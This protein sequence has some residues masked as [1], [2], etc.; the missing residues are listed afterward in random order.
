MVKGSNWI[1]KDR[2]GKITMYNPPVSVFR[3]TE[4]IN[5][6]NPNRKIALEKPIYRL[7]MPVYDNKV[8]VSWR[9][10]AGMMESAE[11]VYDARKTIINK[12]T[13]QTTLVPAKIL[14]KKTGKL[15]QLDVD[16]CREFITD[17]S[18]L[19]GR[20]ELPKLVI[21]TKGFAISQEFRQLIVKRH[22][23]DYKKSSDVVG[24]IETLLFM[25]GEGE[26]DNEEEKAVEAL[27]ELDV[28]SAANKSAEVQPSKGESAV[29]DSYTDADDDDNSS[30]EESKSYPAAQK[31]AAKTA[32]DSSEDES[33][34]EPVAKRQAPAQAKKPA[35]ARKSKK[36]V[37]KKPADDSDDS[38]DF[39]I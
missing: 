29:A 19:T 36:P 39:E 15:C 30:A 4:R 3:Q 28:S 20:L 22:K 7:K 10:K 8:L 12:R 14:N 27:P 18:I 17:R 32:T 33:T 2:N 26:S 1:I 24:S 34:V 6:E 23:S 25:K 21:S 35:P 38:D 5:P 31:T 37:V 11:Y 9:S 13:K 16:N